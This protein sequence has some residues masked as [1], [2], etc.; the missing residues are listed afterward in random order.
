VAQDEELCILALENSEAPEPTT[1]ERR[2]VSV[3]WPS[4][5]DQRGGLWV[6]EFDTTMYGIQEEHSLVP[7]AAV[8]VTL[9]RT[10]DESVRF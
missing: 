1:M 10:M 4:E 6:A 7:S 5:P 8:K 9:A 3:G 2:W